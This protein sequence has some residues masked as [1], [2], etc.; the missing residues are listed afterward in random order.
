MTPAQV[1]LKE[2]VVKAQLLSDQME[3]E[4]RATDRVISLCEA[5]SGPLALT[6]NGR[7]FRHIADPR[8]FN[9]GRTSLKLIWVEIAGPLD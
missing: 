8:H 2:A 3:K 4:R 9:D 6:A 7:I 1:E 5:P